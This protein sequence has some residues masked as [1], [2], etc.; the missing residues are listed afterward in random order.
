LHLVFVTKYRRKVIHAEMLQ[1]MAEVLQCVCNK[2]G[3]TMLEI[4][5]E[6]DHVHLWVD[7][8]PDNNV[9]QLASNLKGASS[10]II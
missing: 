8:H 3:S 6:A 4:N 1:R 10:R 5:A 2:N 7:R 9:S